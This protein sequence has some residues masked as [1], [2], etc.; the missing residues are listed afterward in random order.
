MKTSHHHLKEQL[1]T[2][3]LAEMATD[4]AHDIAHL[5]RVWA[6]AQKISAGEDEGDLRLLL[7]AAY[8]HDMVNVPKN[9]P[10]R[11][12][13]SR[14][15]ANASQ[16]IL[17][18][19][20]FSAPDQES[21]HHIITAHSYSGGVPPETIE[22]KILR[23]ADRLDAL[24]AI[25]VARSFAVAGGLGLAIYDA[26]DPFAQHRTL[27]DKLFALE[28]WRVKLLGLGEGLLCKTARKMAQERLEFMQCYLNQ[29][30]KEIGAEVPENWRS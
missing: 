24:G 2:I 10:D 21:V 12:K 4:P 20:G 8:L 1:R 11:G 22:A 7:A 19:L 16:P 26:D 28:H 30:S 27:N 9:S 15:A 6:N 29:L 3:I 17:T 25:G 5:D 14:M 23:D 18:R 13:A